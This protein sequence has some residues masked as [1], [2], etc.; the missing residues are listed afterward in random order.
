[1]LKWGVQRLRTLDVDDVTLHVEAKN[2]RALGLYERA[3][4]VRGQEWP[5]WSRPLPPA[6]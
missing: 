1:L 2:E 5:R 4:F 6:E 3:G